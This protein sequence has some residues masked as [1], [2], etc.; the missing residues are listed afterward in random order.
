MIFHITANLPSGFSPHQGFTC[1][2]GTKYLTPEGLRSEMDSAVRESLSGAKGVWEVR[3]GHVYATG[4]YWKWPVRGQDSPSWTERMLSRVWLRRC[5]RTSG[6]A[7][8]AC[9]T[10]E[11]AQLPGAGLLLASAAPPSGR[12]CPRLGRS[13]PGTAPSASPWGSWRVASWAVWALW[14]TNSWPTGCC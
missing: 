7:S 2:T 3:S 9:A 14:L 10:P 13:A 12:S 11:R 8:E 6:Q 1:S 4:R 5:W